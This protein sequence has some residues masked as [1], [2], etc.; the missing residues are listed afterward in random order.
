MGEVYLARDLRLGRHVAVKFMT[1]SRVGSSGDRLFLREARAMARLNHP[2]IAT[3]YHTGFHEEQPFLVMELL[4]GESLHVHRGRKRLP[5]PAVTKIA[6]QLIRAVSHAHERGVLHRDLKPGNIFI[7]EDGVLKVLDFGLAEIDIDLS[8]FLSA[9]QQTAFSAH[10]ELGQMPLRAGTPRY[11]APEQWRGELQDERTDV[12]A[13]GVILYEMLAGRAPCLTVEAVAEGHAEIPPLPEDVPASL[14]RLVHAALEPDP[15]ERFPNAH[16][17][18]NALEITPRRTAAA[19]AVP[20]DSAPYR[21][22]ESFSERDEEWFFGRAAQTRQLVAMLERRSLVA[23]VGPPGAGKT[24]LVEAGVIPQLRSDSNWCVLRCP[25]SESLCSALQSN[26]SDAWNAVGFDG[27]LSETPGIVGLVLRHHARTTDTKILLVVDPFVPAQDE[28]LVRA[29]VTAGDDPSSPVRVLVVLCDDQLSHL[30]HV[31]ALHRAVTENLFVLGK[32][33]KTRLTDALTAPA[34]RLG[35]SCDD[36][37]AAQSVDAVADDPTPLPQLQLIASELWEHRNDEQMRLTTGALT[38]ELGGLGNVLV[39]YADKVF[40][41]LL[42]RPG[43]ASI[44]RRVLTHL[45]RSGEMRRSDVISATGSEHQTSEVIDMLVYGH[46]VATTVR[47]GEPLLDLAHDWLACSWD[48]LGIWMEFDEDELAFRDQLAQA[49]RAWRGADSRPGLLW[50]GEDLERAARIATA[51]PDF[52]EVQ[53]AFVEA[54]LSQQ[55][56]RRN[57]ARVTGA[58]AVL[59]ALGVAVGAVVLLSQVEEARDQAVAGQ[60]AEQAQRQRAEAL[61]DY[62]VY[63]L[64]EQLNAAGRVDVLATVLERSRFF[65]TDSRRR[66]TVLAALGSVRAV[67]GRL[68]QARDLLAQADEIWDGVGAEPPDLL[69]RIEVA[70]WRATVA[71]LQGDDATAMGFVTTGEGWLDR[72]PPS[73]QDQSHILRGRLLLERGRIQEDSAHF[74]KAFSLLADRPRE[75]AAAAVLVGDNREGSDRL[76]WYERA[77]GLLTRWLED[78]DADAWAR[79]EL[80]RVHSR[81]GDDHQSGGDLSAAHDQH[82]LSLRLI[83]TLA[84]SDPTNG[85]WQRNLA[86]AA[87]KVAEIELQL[88]AGEADPAL[89]RKHQQDAVAR[90]ERSATISARLAAWDRSR[91]QWTR[92]AAATL[93]Q[94]G[95]LRRQLGNAAGAIV[96]YRDAAAELASLAN[97][98]EADRIRAAHLYL[99]LGDL[100]SEQ[101]ENAAAL[102]TYEQGSAVLSDL[103]T[104]HAIRSRARLLAAQGWIL[105]NQ[106]GDA[107]T[108]LRLLNRALDLLRDMDDPTASD[109]V[110]TNALENEVRRAS[111][112]RRPRVLLDFPDGARRFHNAAPSETPLRDRR[113]YL[114]P[115][116]WR[117]DR[118]F[119]RRGDNERK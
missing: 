85:T 1:R 42:A 68:D 66:A 86:V 94:L 4:I 35:Y 3:I 98:Q 15:E 63:D 54:A 47:D 110:L 32:P 115:A 5:G 82:T 52:P 71:H 114:S 113:R 118:T 7:T 46:L 23:I 13:L 49:A 6:Q 108:A 40:D 39:S 41:R 20:G 38:V 87:E 65:V 95:A 37:L 25:H 97:P 90:L 22:L 117:D 81:L 104:P 72:V 107:R 10:A 28:T 101:G 76:E 75:A 57:L 24:S 96:A 100:W 9:L 91:V 34:Q 17:M 105:G 106:P 14:R 59:V 88:A 12:W 89:A 26:C 93:G 84:T 70:R 69:A 74:T 58:L 60:L 103:K 116:S 45:A 36:G 55:R 79:D 111:A 62:L 119:H 77:R 21:Y 92:E 11:M 61:L 48:R 64:Q 102:R 99:S 78:N 33:D 50:R 19:G 80:A 18:L 31:P 51:T 56:R 16:F 43:D 2:N 83:E 29:L 53:S 109:R 8:S 44:G 27:E 112:I 73:W 67:Q 30:V